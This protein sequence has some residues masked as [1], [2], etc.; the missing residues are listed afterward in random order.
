MG[1]RSGGFTLIELSVTVAVVGVLAAIALPNFFHLKENTER[2]SCVVNQR[3]TV[4]ATTLYIMETNTVAAVLNVTDLWAAGYINP[5]PGECPS[6]HLIDANDYTV[7]IAAE[8]VTAV[9]CLVHPAEHF[10]DNF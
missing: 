10:W 3:H 8:R 9:G 2:A 4:E 1:R 6:E 7:T 5:A